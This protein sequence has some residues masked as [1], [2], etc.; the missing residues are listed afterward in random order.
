MYS[1][2]L[3]I[4]FTNE[5]G[6]SEKVNAR[7]GDMIK[8]L[9]GKLRYAP[10]EVYA[11][12]INN[13]LHS[14]YHKVEVDC[15]CRF[16]TYSSFQGRKMYEAT[17]KFLFYIAMRILYPNVKFK[18]ANKMGADVLI[19]L[20]DKSCDID[21]SKVVYLICDIIA[22]EEDILSKRVRRDKLIDIYFN[23]GH[24]CK[25]DI[26]NP[27]EDD[28]KVSF[29][30][31]DGQVYYNYLYE[32]LLPNTSM[33]HSFRIERYNGDILIRM[34]TVRSSSVC[35]TEITSSKCFELFNS[36]LNFGIEYLSDLNHKVINS[37][38]VNI[39]RL[40]EEAQTMKFVEI[41]Q[42]VI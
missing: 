30:K 21:I 36:N 8:D 10:K 29:I 35:D 5:I 40:A 27:F 16:V 39:I 18:C 15:E 12:I 24:E 2:N 41:T 25:L 28:Y 32:R 42:I 4:C 6:F 13:R 1:N 34:P 20:K 23:M 17:L 38:G 11:V 33:L 37:E 3:Q 9:I 14:V 22:S 31:Y 26:N 19:H 7:E